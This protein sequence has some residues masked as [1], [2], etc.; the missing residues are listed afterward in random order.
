MWRQR[1]RFVVRAVAR[2]PL[3][4][5][6]GLA[7]TGY[8][9]RRIPQAGSSRRWW[10]AA[11]GRGIVRKRRSCR[12]GRV[13]EL[14]QELAGEREDRGATAR[15]EPTANGHDLNRI[16][17]RRGLVEKKDSH[18]PALE[19]FE[20]AAPNQLWQMDGKRVSQQRWT[21]YPLSILDDHS[22]YAV[23]LYG[24]AAFNAE[25]V[26]PCLV[27]TLSVTVCRKRC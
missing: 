21:C 12:T 19:R 10:N 4:R 20:R 6:F 17:K 2:W 27:R 23:G 1:V 16:L 9:W 18:A 26:Y 24:L 13:V 25:Q 8:R 22:R 5:E 11:A 7:P 15:R 14:R 3:C